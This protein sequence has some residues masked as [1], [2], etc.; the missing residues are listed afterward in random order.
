MSARSHCISASDG[1]SNSTVE[2]LSLSQL[3]KKEDQ[4]LMEDMISEI[5]IEFIPL[6]GDIISVGLCRLMIMMNSFMHSQIN[7]IS[8]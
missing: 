6:D 4:Y 8:S 7:K 2:W 1:R 3:K 5:S